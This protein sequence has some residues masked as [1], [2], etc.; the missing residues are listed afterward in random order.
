MQPK[1]KRAITAAVLAGALIGVVISVFGGEFQRR[2]VFDSWQQWAPR[3]NTSDDVVVVMID[4]ESVRKKGQWPWR[5]TDVAALIENIAI[6]Q[7]AAIGVDIFFV[8]PDRLDPKNFLALYNED[9]LAPATR[10]RVLELP[11]GDQY[12]ASV[13]EEAPTVLARV[14]TTDKTRGIGELT[15]ES[16]EGKPPEGIAKADYLLTSIKLLDDA[17]PARGVVDGPP[18]ADGIVRRVP[19]SIIAGETTIAGFALQIATMTRGGEPPEW[20]EDGLKLGETIIPSDTSANLEFKM[21]PEWDANVITALDVLNGKFNVEEMQGKAVI[22]GFGATGTTDI[23]ATPVA[24]EMQGTLVQAQAVDA[25][26]NGHWLSRPGWAQAL[27]LAFALALVAMLLAGGLGIAKWLF[28]PAGVLAA[29]L[30]IGSFVAYDS[31]GL[32]IDPARPL[33]IALCAVIALVLVRYALTFAE[34]VEKRIVT[35]EQEK[36]NESARKLQLTMVPSAARLAKLGT[37]TEIGAVLEPAKSVGGDFYDAMELE[38]NR[39][40]FL[41][42]DVSGKGLRAAL[43]MALSKS[44][45]KNN[46]LRSS[47]DLEAAV[48]QV[49]ADLMAEED[50]EMDLTMLVGVIDCSTG[51][52]EMVNAGHEDPMLV[53]TDGSVEVVKM[54]GGLRLRTLDD[55]PYSVETIQLQAGETLVIITDGATDAMN[56]KEDRFGLERVM[57]ALGSGGGK[58]APDQAKAIASKVRAFERGTDPADDLTILALRY[59]GN[60]TDD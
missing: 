41:V 2:L 4:D 31:A 36:E 60:D 42:G 24:S 33:I 26:L 23:V 28:V 45:S 5:R 40:A 54:R 53:K 1:T 13:I 38:G 21:T 57:D 8:E 9:A 27:E 44:V 25:I 29:A 55:F 10:D 11:G 17:A 58:S 49:N 34:L 6:A 20:T 18:D 48:R 30:P 47:G 7:P 50:E 15:F 37:R 22:V 39:L 12:L 43:F 46:L 52:I 35:A 56:I 32:L 16:I 19:L 14:T 59:L 51:Q 3:S